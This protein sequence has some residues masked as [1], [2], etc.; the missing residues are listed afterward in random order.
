[1]ARRWQCAVQKSKHSCASAPFSVWFLFSD[2]KANAVPSRDADWSLRQ[3]Y[4]DGYRDSLIAAV[5]SL[6]FAVARTTVSAIA[7]SR[8]PL[9]DLR[10]LIVASGLETKVQNFRSR[11]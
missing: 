1:M 6:F 5:A 3:E 8:S 2:T 11:T 7:T 10:S 4:P 9:V